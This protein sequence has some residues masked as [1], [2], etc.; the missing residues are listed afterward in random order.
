MTSGGKT[1]LSVGEG[2]S[3]LVEL[4]PERFN[5][6]RS[7]ACCWTGVMGRA[8]DVG[9]GSEKGIGS[10]TARLNRTPF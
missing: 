2:V 5:A 1:N 7:D 9:M 8:E 6:A 10:E 4:T 3:L